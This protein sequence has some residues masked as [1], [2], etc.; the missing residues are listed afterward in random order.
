MTMKII[1][2][3]LQKITMLKKEFILRTVKLFRF[4]SNNYLCVNGFLKTINECDKS[5]EYKK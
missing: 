3:M 5:Y 4:K 2:T 1:K